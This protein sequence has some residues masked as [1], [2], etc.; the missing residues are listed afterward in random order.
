[1]ASKLFNFCFYSSSKNRTCN[2]FSPIPCCF[3][4][5]VYL[6]LK[7]SN[8]HL[9]KHSC[10]RYNRLITPSSPPKVLVSPIFGLDIFI[11]YCLITVLLLKHPTLPH[12]PI[13]INYYV[14]LHCML[15]SGRLEGSNLRI[16]MQ[17]C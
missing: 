1:M 3:Y 16:S 2:S 15:T 6:S 5:T 8:D 4:S 12:P 17:N 10:E 11:I 13:L 9:G 7:P 14:L